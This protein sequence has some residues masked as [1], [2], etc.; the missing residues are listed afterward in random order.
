MVGV[1]DLEVQALHGVCDREAQVSEACEET[2]KP[3]ELM[4]HAKK[5]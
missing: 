5:A 4:K 2:A 1:L 3:T